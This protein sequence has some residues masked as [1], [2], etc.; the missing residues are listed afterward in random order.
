MASPGYK[1]VRDFVRNAFRDELA[2]LWP[3]DDLDLLIDEA[4]REY[5]LMTQAL[6]GEVT[7]TSAE[8]GLIDLPGDFISPAKAFTS[9][10][11]EVPF[12]SWRLLETLHP[13][14]R[15]VTG[16]FVQAFCFDFETYGRLRLYP[17]VPVGEV[18]GKLVYHRFPAA[19]TL[20]VEDVNA[21]EQHVLFQMFLLSGKPSSGNH[22]SQFLSAVNEYTG[23][24]RR[25]SL[26]PRGR[27][28]RF[29]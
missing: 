25:L 7:I 19:G 9:D 20:E 16:D 2:T 18:V 8:R 29:F 13:D 1:A 11:L 23:S 10:G 28:G 15:S 17:V 27:S 14:F 21:I 26:R 24:N 5:C 3:D 4:Q 6:T 22:Y 12:I